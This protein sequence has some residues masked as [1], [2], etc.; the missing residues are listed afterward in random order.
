MGFFNK[1]KKYK[2]SI[3]LG[4]SDYQSVVTM[5]GETNGDKIEWSWNYSPDLEPSNLGLNPT[6]MTIDRTIMAI[7]DGSI[8]LEELNKGKI[9]VGMYGECRV[10]KYNV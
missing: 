5:Y 10:N 9:H 4:D 8:S 2:Y 6:L 7:V 3:H 1:K